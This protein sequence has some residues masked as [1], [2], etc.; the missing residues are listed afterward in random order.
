[1]RE[2]GVEIVG[3]TSSRTGKWRR[4]N[5]VPMTRKRTRGC[6]SIPSLEEAPCKSTWKSS[7]G[8]P[9]ILSAKLK[10]FLQINAARINKRYEMQ[11]FQC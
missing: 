11:G 3:N 10:C 4:V 8:K 7:T 2:L 6:V 1:M 9:E 5:D